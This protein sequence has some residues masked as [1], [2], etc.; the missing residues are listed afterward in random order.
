MQY[1][2]RQLA[3][4]PH[5]NA[6][7]RSF[8]FIVTY[9]KSSCRQAGCAFEM[10]GE[11]GGYFLCAH[12]QKLVSRKNIDHSERL[13]YG[14][15]PYVRTNYELFRAWLFIKRGLL[16]ADELFAALYTACFGT[17]T[18]FRWQEGTAA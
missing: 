6:L 16:K 10:W 1:A 14:N 4:G 7:S 18:L 12:F 17:K 5:R 13:A 8:C 11:I 2:C 3:F 9:R 15:L